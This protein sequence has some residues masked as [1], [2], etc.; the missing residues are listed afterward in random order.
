MNNNKKINNP[1]ITLAILILIIL[2][3]VLI[4]YLL[5]RFHVFDLILK[6]K[7]NRHKKFKKNHENEEEDFPNLLSKDL[8]ENEEL[9]DSLNPKPPKT[10][11]QRSKK[12]DIIALNK[13]ILRDNEYIRD[14]NKKINMMNKNKCDVTPQETLFQQNNNS[15]IFDTLQASVKNMADNLLMLNDQK[16]KNLQDNSF[17]LF[18]E[19]E[20]YNLIQE[21]K[22]KIFKK[23]FK[24]NVSLIE[25]EEQQS[26]Q[27]I[28]Q[29]E[30]FP[31]PQEE[32]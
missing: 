15:P 14:I 16:N 2:V 24:K 8:I 17:P 22:Q 21:E 10:I 26:F 18:Q 5:Y 20:K 13:K 25:Q 28:V 9:D 7:I 6:K 23:M 11:L 19:E 27:P 4:F 30:Y 31:Y 12:N 3:V 1:I 29:E 32:S